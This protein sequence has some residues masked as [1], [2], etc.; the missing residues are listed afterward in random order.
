[1]RTGHRVNGAEQLLKL[2]TPAGIIDQPVYGKVHFFFCFRFGSI[3][4]Y[5]FFDELCFSSLQHFSHTIQYLA[6][7]KS[8]TAAPAAKGSSCSHYGIPE[9]FA[10]A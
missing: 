6:A 3:L 5:Q 1:M 7:V 2:I 10:G 9:I 4:L 8:G